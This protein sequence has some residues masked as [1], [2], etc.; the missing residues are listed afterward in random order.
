[1][2]ILGLYAQKRDAEKYF[3]LSAEL[4][5]KEPPLQIDLGMHGSEHKMPASDLAGQYT[6]LEMFTYW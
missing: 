1:M 2:S 5:P 6:V 3:A 4:L